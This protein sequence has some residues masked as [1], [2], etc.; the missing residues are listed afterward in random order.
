MAPAAVLDTRAATLAREASR[1]AAQGITAAGGTHREVGLRDPAPLQPQHQYTELG[2]EPHPLRKPPPSRCSAGDELFHPGRG[3]RGALASGTLAVPGAG[4]SPGR[5]LHCTTHRVGAGDTA[6]PC[7]ATTSWQTP[8]ALQQQLTPAR[9]RDRA[10]E[11]PLFPRTRQQ[12]RCCVPR[13]HRQGY[14]AHRAPK[15]QKM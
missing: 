15:K 12:P 2:E 5:R 14:L 10:V 6:G 4:L 11:W 8:A 13:V 9:L 3:Q 7:S 1:R